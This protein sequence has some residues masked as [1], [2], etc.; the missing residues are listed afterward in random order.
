MNALKQILKWTI[1]CLL[2]FITFN[3]FI[4]SDYEMERTV[5]IEVHTYIVYEKVTDLHNWPHWA[6][7]W[8]NDT[9]IITNYT[10]EEKGLGA[11]MDWNGEE[12]GIGALEI[13][14]CSLEGMETQLDF[15]NMMASGFW[16]FDAIDGGTKVT[17]G[18]K[19]EMPF[20]MRF[21]TLF[22]DAMAGADF[23]AGLQGL[24]EACESMPARSS[25]VTVTDWE[26]QTFIYIEN[27]CTMGDIG[28]S[29]G[30]T[31]GEL[32]GFIGTN[33]LQPLS[34]PFAKWISFP[35]NAGDEDKVVFQAAVMVATATATERVRVGSTSAGKT[36]QSTHYGAYEMSE[37]THQKMHAYAVENSLTLSAI[38]FEFY[39]NDPTTVAPEDVETL[40]VYE[41]VE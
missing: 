6:V 40:I 15:G 38:A 11:K 9:T 18:M 2:A 25:E 7:W 22:L 17:W 12:A 19:G 8:E 3:F 20:F 41:V 24:K 28:N 5:E 35:H 16:H 39:E 29:L 33:G 31:Y 27:T 37:V 13:I 26:K 34:S 4:S 21:M 14:S 10:G 36:L 1:I 30:T 32:F 23:E